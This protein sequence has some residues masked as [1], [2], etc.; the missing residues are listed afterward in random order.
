MVLL[1]AFFYAAA[2]FVLNKVTY[3]N[4]RLSCH[5]MPYLQKAGGQE[6]LM[7]LDFQ[8]NKTY[9]VLVYGSSHVYRGY[10]PR[11][12]E[13]HGLSLFDAGS[14]AQSTRGSL[15]LAKHLIPPSSGTLV[16]FDRKQQFAHP[17]HSKQRSQN[18]V[19]YRATRHQKIQPT[20]FFVVYWITH[21]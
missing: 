19:I 5:F 6:R 17:K 18:R 9:D 3:K 21:Y 16:I 4:K 7:A 13:R 14:S 10:D 1:S 20:Y 8:S 15:I 12:F 2:M 11:N